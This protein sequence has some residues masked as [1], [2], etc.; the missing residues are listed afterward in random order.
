VVTLENLLL[1]ITFA[2]SHIYLALPD[3]TQRDLTRPDA[4]WRDTFVTLSK[5]LDRGHTEKSIGHN[6]HRF[7]LFD[8]AMRSFMTDRSFSTAACLNSLGS[9]RESDCDG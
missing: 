4:I 5:L 1:T 7:N 8:R 3:V 9:V 6:H 2:W